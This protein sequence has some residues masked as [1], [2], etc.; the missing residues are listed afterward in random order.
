MSLTPQQ[1]K[2]Q[3]QQKLRQAG[4]WFKRRA[5]QEA[6]YLVYGTLGGLSLWP[7]VQ[8][9]QTGGLTPVEVGIALGGVAGSVGTN[10]LANQ[11]QSWKDRAKGPDEDE[12]ARWLAKNATESEALREALDTLL[13]QMDAI[14]Q[15]QAGLSE[16]DRQWFLT[17]LHAEL[18]GL[19]NLP[20]FEATLKGSGLIVQGDRA[21]GIQQKKESLAIVG[22]RIEGDVL[23][24]GASKTEVLAPKEPGPTPDDL[25]RAYLNQLFETTGRLSLAGID[26]KAA[27]EAEARLN[28][29]AIYTALLTQ[30]ADVERDIEL[31]PRETLA[32]RMEA[33]AAREPRRL[34]ALAQLNRQA[35]LVLLGDPGSGKS[36]FVN[37]VTM[38]LAGEALGRPRTNL[39]KLT[40]PLPDDEGQDQE[41]LQP[42]EHGPLLPV[43]VILRDFAARGLPP[44]G[45]T[46]TARHLW[47][48]IVA[49]LDSVGLADFAPCLR[50]ELMQQGGLLLLDGLDEVPEAHQRRVQ[51]REAVEG[52]ASAYPRCRVL[53]TSRTYAYQQQAWR[54]PSF[55][56]AVLAPFSAGQ[57]RRFVDGW[58][59]HIAELRG[60]H[61][62]D[63]QGRAELLKRAIFGSTRLE[64]LAERPLLLTLMASLHAWRGGSLPE[65]R[66]ELYADTVDLLLDWWESP[67]TVRDA[68]GQVMVLQPSLA[69][70]LKVDRAKVRGLLNQLAYQAHAAQPDLRGTADVDEGLLVSELIR[71]SQNPEVNPA[72]LIEYLS[73]RAGLLLP[74]GVGVYTFPHRTFQEYLAACHLTDHDYPDAVAELARAEPD[75]WREVALLAGAKAARG[76]ASSIW[77]LA[78]ALC[79]R[80]PG[81]AN[82]ALADVWGA[83]MAGQA[84]TETTDLTQISE[85]NQAKV[86]RVQHWLAHLISGSD[87]PAVERVS[88]GVMLAYLGDPRPGVGLRADGLPD[89]TWCEIPAGPFLMGDDKQKVTLPAYKM[90]RYPVTNAQFKAFVEAGGYQEAAFWTE[91]IEAGDWRKGQ[92]KRS[93]PFFESG[94]VKW[95][96]EW[97]NAPYDYGSPFNLA[98]HPVVG[99]NW[100][101]ALAF[102]R[103]LSAQLGEQVI[104]P[105]E[106]QWEKA[107]RGDDGREYPWG[108]EADPE[109]ANYDETGL[110]ATSAV[111]CFGGGVSPYGCLDMAGNV[112]EWCQDW[113]DEDKDFRVLRGGS[114]LSYQF[115]ARCSYRGSRWP[116]NVRDYD[117]GFRLVVSPL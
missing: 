74:R 39:T 3:A 76:T 66:E 70:W 15:A 79:F 114:W 100:Y 62:D 21:I 59:A 68:G 90:S 40:A 13:E 31:R 48:F 43:R 93:V 102:C 7:L 116:L 26:P 25:R 30:R 10:L 54:L 55:S 6:P 47:D 109:W 91:A 5:T 77:L 63:A 81:A 97:A 16:A 42:W 24:P 53:V 104:L 101:E 117:F 87:L 35:R 2:Q 52:F 89:I 23:G 12:V 4:G 45:Q 8:A 1:W 75:R 51:L 34:S 37:F 111:G 56:E 86:A 96:D 83:L 28:L 69:E 78:E 64:A 33:E 38:C 65:K 22:S 107:A 14:T 106:T 19:G 88:A 20:R 85:R 72:R 108:D 49:E 80:K 17:T 73:Q 36:T 92:V 99:V 44:V 105:D 110:G 67:K 58:Y 57:I 60:L 82:A 27:S 61:P 94:D 71:L 18:A 46:A 98:N 11:I 9:A 95:R 32:R 112:W 113:Y 84:L 115:S 29:S 41:E 50:Q 103:W